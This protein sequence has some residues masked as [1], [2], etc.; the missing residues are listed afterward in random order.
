MDMTSLPLKYFILNLY[1][2]RSA[3]Q[4]SSVLYVVVNY[5]F[6]IFFNIYFKLIIIG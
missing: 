5:E 3:A 4:D 6:V 1:S 2:D